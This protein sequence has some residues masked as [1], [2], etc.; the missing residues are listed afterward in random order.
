M[1]GRSRSTILDH[2][3]KNNLS[4]ASFSV[5]PAELKGKRA[6]VTGGT[7]GIG[8][9]IVRRLLAGGATVVAS[10]RTA[11]PDLPAGVT[12]V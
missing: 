5:D 8:A 1:T 9:G 7:R 2:M 6:L 3:V 11:V 4:S 10:A 12:F